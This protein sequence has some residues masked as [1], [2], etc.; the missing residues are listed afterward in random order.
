MSAINVFTEE[1]AGSKRAVIP[2]GTIIKARIG[3]DGR[4]PAP[5]D[6]KQSV[7][8]KLVVIEPQQ[9]AGIEIYDF[10]GLQGKPYY[11]TRGKNA[12]MYA[13]DVNRDAYKLLP[14]QSG[15]SINSYAEFNGMEVLCKVK[16]SVDSLRKEN[17]E[18]VYFH[19]NEIESYTTP[20]E[21]SSSHKYFEA[22]IHGQQPWQS[23][24]LPP[25]PSN[26]PSPHMAAK[27]NGYQPQAHYNDAPF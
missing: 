27:Q 7:M 5:R 18:T 4:P 14:D 1:E 16:V 10:I 2:E 9:Y 13:L 19:K 21:N 11:V 12:M 26:T 25:L 3:T 22:W 6:G 20:R 24:E 23:D 17:G 15:Y 8:W